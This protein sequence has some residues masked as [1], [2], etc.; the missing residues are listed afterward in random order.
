MGN[1]LTRF[2]AP[3]FT[4][5]LLTA[6][7]TGCGHGHAPS[8]PRGRL[9]KTTLNVSVVPAMDSAGFF[10]AL[11]DGLFAQRG[12]RVNY[13][14]ATS[15]DTVIDEQVAGKFDVT[16]GNYVSYIQHYVNDRQPLEIISEGSLTQTGTQALYIMP[17]SKVRALT[18]LRG[19][20]LGINAPDNINYLLAASAL[21]ESGIPLNSVRFPASPIPFPMMGAALASGQ[22]TAAA[23]PEPFA[24]EAQQ[25]YGAV[26][27]TDLD[28]G[29]TQGFPIEG[30]VVTRSWAARNPDTLKA[31][32]AALA[33]GQQIADTSRP[34]VERAM[35]SLG[36]AADGQVTPIVGSAMSLNDYP[37]GIDPIRLQ[38]VID[39][40]V[41]FGLLQ[42]GFDI[43]ALLPA[44]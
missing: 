38:R 26:V 39:V 33:Q 19:Q 18:D 43:H 34:A 30:Y 9:E 35:E 2:L 3:V 6:A 21:T 8:G 11:H 32:Q 17:H 12:L 1:A 7:L 5:T 20:V 13:T 22:V 28:Q 16:A 10:V 25:K 31:F 37:I 44:R 24:T 27:L 36:G 4:T 40:M 23:L 15:S 14:P 42:N 41:Q 29:M